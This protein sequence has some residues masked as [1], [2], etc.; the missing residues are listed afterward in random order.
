MT[1]SSR[2]IFTATLPFALCLI[3][4]GQD[5]IGMI[6][7]TQFAS[8]YRA[9]AILSFGQLMN[10]AFGSVG[11]ILNMTGNEKSSLKGQAL[12][13]LINFALNI[14]LIPKWGLEGAAAATC[15]SLIIWNILLAAL[16]F[17]HLRIHTT[18]LGKLCAIENQ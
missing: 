3:F 16:V 1:Y 7:G 5:I 10:A 13:L 18:A 17:K 14:V 11:L 4:Y 15:I 6:Y 2:L 8:G 9:L 12:A